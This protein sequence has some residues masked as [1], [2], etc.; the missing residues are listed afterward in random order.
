MAVLLSHLCVS[1]TDHRPGTVHTIPQGE[2]ANR[3]TS[4]CRFSPSGSSHPWKL[5]GPIEERRTFVCLP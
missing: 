3:E 1:S 2:G 5:S 4:S